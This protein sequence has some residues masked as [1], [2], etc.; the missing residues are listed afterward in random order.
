MLLPR[1]RHLAFLR[2]RQRLLFFRDHLGLCSHIRV[3]LCIFL[4]LVR[5]VVLMKNCFH[6]TL[7]DASLAVNALLGVNVQHLFPFVKALDWANDN[8]ICISAAD[9]GL[10]NNVGHGLKPFF[11]SLSNRKFQKTRPNRSQ[12][13]LLRD[14]AQHHLCVVPHRKGHR[15]TLQTAQS[16]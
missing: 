12:G 16:T 11:R 6:G 14:C 8:A 15:N 5:N 2:I 9:A 7:G 13:V 4:P 1:I 3:H 10:S